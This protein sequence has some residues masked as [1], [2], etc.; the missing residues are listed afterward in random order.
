MAAEPVRI[1]VPVEMP[2]AVFDIAARGYDRD[3]VHQYVAR[4]EQELA[5]LRWEKE[6]VEAREAEL[7]TRQDELDRRQALIDAW[8]PSW[9]ALGERAQQVMTST[10]QQA[11][12][13]RAQAA[14]ESTELLSQAQAECAQLRTA[15]EQEADALRRSAHRLLEVARSDADR[16]RELL[17][18][19]LDRKR[20]DGELEVTG[21][22]NRAQVT[23]EETIAAAQRK[24]VRITV[25]AKESLA[26][27]QR[28]RD[29][30]AR[31][32]DNL[33]GRLQSVAA[34]LNDGIED[35]D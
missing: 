22:V 8:E 20:R 16:L 12:T 32:L 13:L 14:Q 7:A 30:I 5:E 17:D 19:D 31:H 1:P 10:Q 18:L 24:A 2:V 3:Q 23:A 6:F 25:D 29:E 27:L 9:A 4:L 35:D 11:S 26:R 28:E 15:A 21:I 33:V 34:H